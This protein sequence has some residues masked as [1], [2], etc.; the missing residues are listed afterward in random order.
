MT[1]DYPQ[2]SLAQQIDAKQE[3]FDR[4]GR[5]VQAANQAYDQAQDGTEAKREA[6]RTI[7]GLQR[8][9]LTVEQELDAITDAYLAQAD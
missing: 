6:V 5:Q 3:A 2:S 1:F 8:E 9:R 7:S 4:L